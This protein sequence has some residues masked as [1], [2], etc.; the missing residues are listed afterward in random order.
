MKL[1]KKQEKP[2][3]RSKNVIRLFNR[4]DDPIAA[5]EDWE[6]ET[7]CKRDRRDVLMARNKE[8]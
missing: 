4:P 3:K 8:K 7:N 5:Y 1:L 6:Q 2:L